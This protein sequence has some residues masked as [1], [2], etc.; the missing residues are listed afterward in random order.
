MSTRPMTLADRYPDV[1]DVVDTNS[2]NIPRGPRTVLNISEADCLWM[3]NS[4]G[5]MFRLYP[6]HYPHFD[7]LFRADGGPITVEEETNA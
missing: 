6:N 1:G 3:Q 7:Y 5:F 4:V 2:G